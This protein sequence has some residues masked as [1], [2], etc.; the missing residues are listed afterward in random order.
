MTLCRNHYHNQNSYFP[1]LV[2]Y[3]AKIQTGRHGLSIDTN[4]SMNPSVIPNKFSVV[5]IFT[6]IDDL[7]KL[8]IFIFSL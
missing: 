2:A 3:N 5:P 1:E 8:S 4:D 6:K 7:F